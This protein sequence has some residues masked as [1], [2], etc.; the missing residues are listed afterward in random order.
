VSR[1]TRYDWDGAPAGSEELFTERLFELAPIGLLI[2]DRELRVRRMNR[3]MRTGTGLSA[4]GAV[5]RPSPRES[6]AAVHPAVLAA[7]HRVLATGTPIVDL[8]IPGTTG[9]GGA[10]SAGSTGSTRSTEPERRTW[11][12]SHFPIRAGDGSVAAVG[13][14]VVDVTEQRRAEAARTAVQERLRLLGR[15][16]GLVG[17]SLDL[18]TTLK[19]M[20]ELIVPEFADTCELY[21]TGEP[22]D[23][24]AP[25]PRLPLRLAIAGNTPLLPP[26]E[27]EQPPPSAITY[28]DQRNPAHRSITLRRPILFDVDERV[29]ASV[30]Q[31]RRDEHFDYIAVRTAITV[32]LLVGNAYH[33]AVYFGLGPSG[34]TYTEYDVETAGELGGRIAHAV[35]NARAFERQHRAAITLQRGLLP[36]DL[37][38][39]E[40][41]DLESRYEP[42][43]A[44]TEVGGDWFEV[45]PLSAGRVALVIGDVMGRGLTAAAVM[46]QV[47]AAVR[48][49]AALDL[50]ASDVLTHLD[51]LITNLAAGPDGALVSCVYAIFEPATA[52]ITVAN[53]GHLP[54]ALVTPNGDVRLLAEPDGIILGVGGA[55]FSEARYP[56]PTGGT[57]AL[58]TNGLVESPEI[59]IG[60]GVE[61]LL[62]ALAT[63]GPTDSAAAGA[64]DSATDGAAAAAFPAGGFA[65]T[66]DLAGTADRLLTLID[67]AGGYDDD[68]ALLLVRATARATTRT[69]TVEPEPRAAKA[70]RDATVAALRQWGL[71]DS[72]DLVE[73]LV[74]ELVTN[75]IRYA[76]TPS[77][78]TLRRGRHALYVEIADRDSRVPRLLHP[79]ADDEGGRGLQLVAQ[80]ATQWG[81]RPTRTGKTVWFEL[82]LEP[83]PVPDAVG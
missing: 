77:D 30:D 79:T 13:V 11:R 23:A 78:L 42:G 70:A 4:D 73:L 22:L 28:V 17:A 26:P 21:L 56:F 54:P 33:G 80:L 47:R 34:R 3:A 55:P 36:G 51:N 69:T 20:V 7:V 76:Q 16:G 1:P 64:T 57:L 68:V 39:I 35:A 67:R 66:A 29:I 62:A 41:L 71:T 52:S 58:Y 2:I 53:A 37:P 63:D 19:G 12:V 60:Q 10:G 74:S 75:A 82:D 6:L 9:N 45:V 72:V 50:P 46:G 18:M 38:A 24:S 61:R 49:F 59:D 44:G 31:P 25:P 27:G 65:G 81:A 40:D 5:E 15:A 32:P 8:E 83:Q 48:A 14:A 43:T